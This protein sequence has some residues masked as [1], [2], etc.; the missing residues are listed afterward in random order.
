MKLG[1]T[2]RFQDPSKPK[3]P[4]AEDS[5]LDSMS[6]PRNQCSI[7]LGLWVVVAVIAFARGSTLIDLPNDQQREE[8]TSQHTTLSV[9]L[10][11]GFIDHMF[12]LSQAPPN[13]SFT[14]L[15]LLVGAFSK[16][17]NH[18]GGMHNQDH[19]RLENYQD[20]SAN[21]FFTLNLQIVET[22]MGI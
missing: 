18:A 9:D 4:F 11:H 8:P 14:H 7:A 6:V 17:G 2:R 21:L 12:L 1:L 22:H 20:S 15:A 16:E 19:F 10:Y 5:N 13:R 3:T